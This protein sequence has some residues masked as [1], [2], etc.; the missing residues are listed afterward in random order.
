MATMNVAMTMTLADAGAS[1]TLRAF[2]SQMQQLQTATNG[3]AQRLNQVAAGITAV[4]RATAGGT[5]IQQM[6]ARLAALSNAMTTVQARSTAA[7]AA[8]G[9][10]GQRAASSQGGI[11]ALATGMQALSS[12]MAAMTGRLAAVA[13]NLAGIG[14]AA[15][16]AGAGV[17]QGVAGMGRGLAAANQQAGTLRQTMVGLAQVWAASKI[18]DGLVS[19][20]TGAMKF[21][22]AQARAEGAGMTADERATI[23]GAAVGA[24]RT[25]PQFDRLQHFEMGVDLRNALNDTQAAA[26]LL[27]EM[28]KVAQVLRAQTPSGQKFDPSVLLNIGKMLQIRDATADPA[29]LKAE[30]E[31]I[32]KIYTSSQGRINTAMFLQTLKQAKGGLGDNFDLGFMPVLASMMEQGGEKAGQT[33]TALTSMSNYV[34]GNIKNGLAAKEANRLGL[35]EKEPVWNSQGNIDLKKSELRLRGADLFMRNPYEWVQK[36]LLPA[37]QRVGVSQDDPIAVNSV[38]ARLMP[39]RNARDVASLMATKSRIIDQDVSL[40]GRAKGTDDQFKL[41]SQTADMKWE[42][43][44][45]QARDLAIVMGERLLPALKQIFE[46]LTKAAQGLSGFFEAHPVVAT[47]ATWTAAFAALGLGITGMAAMFGIA[48]R[49][50]AFLWGPATTAVAAFGTAFRTMWAFLAPMLPALGAAVAR[51]AA[52]IGAVL[53]RLIPGV[54]LF[55]AAWSIASLIGDLEIGGKKIKDWAAD[56]VGWVVDAFKSGWNF[57]GR[58]VTSVI[59]GAQAAEARGRAGPAF[60][61]GAGG[62]WTPASVTL[63]AT[64]AGA[65][66]GSINPGMPSTTRSAAA[67]PEFEGVTFAPEGGGGRRSIEKLPHSLG[68]DISP[69]SPLKSSVDAVKEKTVAM[70]GQKFALQDIAGAVTDV[71]E[72]IA[73]VT[74][75]MQNFM[76]GANHGFQ[77]FFSG[78]LNG[79]ATLKQ[80][81]TGLGMHILQTVNDIIAKRLADQLMGS[82]FGGGGGFGAPAGGGGG[83]I[84]GSLLGSVLGGGAPAAASGGGI[85]SFFSGLFGGGG[86]MSAGSA[87]AALLGLPGFAS[88]IDY[89]PHDM[90]AMIHKGERVMPAAENKAFTQNGRGALNVTNN[91]ML[92]GQVDKRTQQQIQA[93]AGRGVQSAFSRGTA[94]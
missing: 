3:V 79:T 65:G 50:L 9:T 76:Y 45:A 35:M 81:F 87:G 2:T 51:M 49:P 54:G 24:T 15:R 16:A 32:V 89:V 22:T 26:A 39:N 61:G 70:E 19:A 88:G 91:F 13:N 85:G 46:W 42:A 68:K 83:G 60:T 62:S 86:G 69:I 6:T 94:P 66:R 30:T 47:L 57:I 80:S 18:K 64:G 1:A 93:A 77:Q 7:G 55:L 37:L 92:S 4:G 58:I 82:L 74:P 44:K 17:Q 28:A 36:F 43:T 78:I 33:G 29:R 71:G 84:F 63:P 12:Q 25:V 40:T 31:Q 67:M 20:A 21:E 73:E 14:T 41:L 53:L 75:E 56:L 72:A 10:V 11:A 59:P 52:G 27:P 38:L 90:G 48:L 8:L 23:R 5:G 34:L